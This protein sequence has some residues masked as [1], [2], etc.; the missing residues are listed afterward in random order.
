[1]GDLERCHSIVYTGS[2]FICFPPTNITHCNTCMF[3]C[4]SLCLFRDDFTVRTEGV[5]GSERQLAVLHSSSAPD[6][7]Y[8]RPVKCQPDLAA[9]FSPRNLY[10][11][12]PADLDCF[13]VQMLLRT[14]GRT[15]D[16]SLFV[17]ASSMRRSK[18]TIF[19]FVFC[20]IAVGDLRFSYQ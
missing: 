4:S 9:T 15:R 17:L 13:P 8:T 3:F 10:K 16:I 18:H 12:P 11:P 5:H 2:H 20:F 14:L 7:K 19:P 6:Y 1:M